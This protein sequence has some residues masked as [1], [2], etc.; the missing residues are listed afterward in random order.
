MAV[1]Q[2]RA[3]P[4]SSGSYSILDRESK[5]L[6]GKNKI[7]LQKLIPVKMK[8]RIVPDEECHCESLLFFRCA[9]VGALAAGGAVVLA[10][11]LI[12]QSQHLKWI[13]S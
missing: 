3:L 11:P 7:K 2:G 9:P 4:N 12:E 5:M 8:Q 10:A 13:N 1:R 6:E